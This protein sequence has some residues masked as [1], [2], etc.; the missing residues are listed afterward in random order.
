VRDMV[1]IVM[2]LVAVI[3]KVFFFFFLCEC[4]SQFVCILINSTDPEVNNHVDFQWF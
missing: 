4:P 3:S 1:F 2:V